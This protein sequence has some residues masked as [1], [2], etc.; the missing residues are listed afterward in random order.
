VPEETCIWALYVS[1]VLPRNSSKLPGLLSAETFNARDAAFRGG[2]IAKRFCAAAGARARGLVAKLRMQFCC[3]P[4]RPGW[5]VNLRSAN[6]P[7]A[8]AQGI[9]AESPQESASALSEDLQRIARF[10]A[11]CAKNAPED[12]RFPNKYMDLVLI[13]RL[14]CGTR[15][16]SLTI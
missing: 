7:A 15:T 4:V 10:L 11:L 2:K 6:S 16:Y 1:G 5:P 3:S 12:G 13:L 8:R 14:F 9:A